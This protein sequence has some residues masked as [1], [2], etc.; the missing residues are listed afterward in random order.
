[1]RNPLFNRYHLREYIIFG[2]AGALLYSATIWYFLAR[3][4]Y[5]DSWIVFI[6]NGLFMLMIIWYALRLTTR[7]NDYK[8]VWK[9]LMAGHLAALVGITFCVI[10]CMI[11]C[12]IY[13]P[14]FMS[15]DSK[16]AFLQKAPEGMN[17]D[18]SGTLLQIFLPATI[19]NFGSAAFMSLVISYVLKPNQT[20][21]KA[22][23][24]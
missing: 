23:P 12:F 3:A 24:L 9:M 17:V 14:G 16:D 10:F 11:L 4:R 18:N 1:M 7:R 19:G 8:S 2:G 15:G 6:G 20:K 13:I 5:A 21:D 22:A